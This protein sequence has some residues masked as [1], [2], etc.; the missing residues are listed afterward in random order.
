[1]LEISALTSM[2]RSP[3]GT[4]RLHLAAMLA[5][6]AWLPAAQAAT[7]APVAGEIQ[8]I[9]I[10][11][12]ADHWSGG[13]IQVGGQKVIIPR[14]LLID[15]PANRVTLK[16][17]YDEAPVTCVAAA[18]T[19]LAKADRCNRSGMGA[20]A[21]ISA[22]RVNGNLIAGDVLISKG[23]ETVTG[24]I[25]YIN[26]DDGYFRV[27]GNSND[28]DTGVMVRLND[29]DGRHTVQKGL[30]CGGGP[31]CSADPRFTLDPDN[32]TN[33]FS[34]GYPLCI[35]STV[36]RTVPAPGLPTGLNGPPAVPAG[37]VAQAVH[38]GS[39]DVLCPQ[40]NRG[41]TPVDDSRRF[42]PIQ[43]G[44]SITA[45]GNFETVNGTQF[46]SAH[47]TM[48]LGALQTK[49]DADQPD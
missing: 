5:L 9:A 12:S 26:Y 22:N 40:T 45:E 39:G 44:D 30:G 11:D 15:L 33:T 36:A 25:T 24:E 14:N 2:L 10:N 20:I 27:N 6:A 49:A 48:V 19:G 23:V 1:M 46:L 13:T 42:A 37:T 18:E 8:R 34:S 3:S 28:P 16:Q 47:T 38:N 4:G 21:T 31:N 35:P 7:T 17:L 29:P 43:V 32:Y 41:T